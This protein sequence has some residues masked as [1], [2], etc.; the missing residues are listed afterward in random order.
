MG[1]PETHYSYTVNCYGTMVTME[2]VIFEQ[3][4]YYFSISCAIFNF[5]FLNIFLI[6]NIDDTM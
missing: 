6:K 2:T 1:H 5:K 4:S 3:N